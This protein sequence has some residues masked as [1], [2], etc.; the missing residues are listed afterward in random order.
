MERIKTEQ[1]PL[2]VSSQLLTN[3][4]VYYF[5]F[6]TFKG[7]C[8]TAGSKKDHWIALTNKRILYK[9]KISDEKNKSFKESNGI[10]PF[11]KISLMEIDSKIEK[12]GCGCSGTQSF[13][14]KIASSGT[15]VIIPIPTEAKAYEI[16]KA[17]MELLELR[18]EN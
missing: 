11:D 1:L 13:N 17:Y 18:K 12:G 10:I 3:E 8:G 16:R 2:G 6:I 5:S 7:G 4:N 14:L 15:I 9:S